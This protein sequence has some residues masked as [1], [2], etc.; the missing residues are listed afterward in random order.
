MVWM[1]H[2]SERRKDR[3][4]GGARGRENAVS[5]K[6]GPV[7]PNLKARLEPHGPGIH[8]EMV[9]VMVSMRVLLSA[10]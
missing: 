2:F 3:S 7:S 1:A 4:D 9:E 5:H 10:D 8:P 6:Y